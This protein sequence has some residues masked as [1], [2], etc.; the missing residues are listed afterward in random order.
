MGYARICRSWSGLLLTGLAVLLLTGCELGQS[1]GGVAV[2]D[3]DVVASATG[4][5]KIISEQVQEF[6]RAQEAKLRELKSELEQQVN[7]ASEKLDE[8]A[9]VEEKQ[10][11]NSLIVDARTQ[12]TREL[13]QARQSAQQLR[14]RLV[15]DFAV[16]VQPVARRVAA[17]RGLQIV[18][19]KQGG[20][21]VVAPEVDITAAV[22][23]E[24]QTGGSVA[25]ALPGTQKSE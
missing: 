16:E 5:D 25:P 9:S 3:L 8:A 7:S 22:V 23:D 15:R 17:K 14:Q 18:M 4:R 24:L 12:L 19:V 11:L 10:S 13:G 2:I 1:K 20:L 6:A 21:L